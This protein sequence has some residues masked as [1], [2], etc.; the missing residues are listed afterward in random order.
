M[1]AEPARRPLADAAAKRT[2]GAEQRVNSA[3]RALD[4]EGATVTFA[5]VASRA[6]VSRAFLYAHAEL[7]S[8]IEVLR[9]AQADTPRRLAV[10]HRA[11]DASVR[12]RLRAALDEGQRQREEI[13]RMREELALAHG[14]VRELELDRRLRRP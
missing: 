8:E 3:L 14:R 4:S 12:V 10:R 5:A 7:R 9:S 2:L 13:A 1:S 6:R 11:S